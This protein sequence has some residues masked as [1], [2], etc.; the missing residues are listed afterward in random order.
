MN[1]LWGNR[2]VRIASRFRN[3]P[4]S[5]MKLAVSRVG[6]KFQRSV[7]DGAGAGAGAA[8]AESC[9]SLG[10]Y[11][12][13][14]SAQRLAVRA[15]NA[16]N[17]LK[18]AR[19]QIV[20][21]ETNFDRMANGAV[22]RS[23]EFERKLYITQSQLQRVAATAEAARIR[24]AAEVERVRGDL[25][26]LARQRD[27]A[28]GELQSA[29]KELEQERSEVVRAANER[30]ERDAVHKGALIE[31]E[32]MKVGLVALRDEL[33]ATAKERDRA[34]GELAELRVRDAN[35]SRRADESNLV[36]HEC[37]RRYGDLSDNVLALSNALSRELKLLKLSDNLNAD[38]SGDRTGSLYL[39]LIEGSLI[40]ALHEDPAGDP[41]S[42]GK[43]D[44]LRRN[45]GRDWPKTA[46][47]MIGKSRMRNIRHLL[48]TVIAEKIPGDV[49]EAGVWRGGACIYMKAILAAYGIADRRVWVADSFRG[50]PQPDAANYPADAGDVHH[51]YDELAISVDDV[52]RNFAR[53]G[54]LDDQVCFL[55]GWFKDTMPRAPIDK[56]ALLRLDGDM[57]ESTMQVLE[58]LYGKV[59]TG[60]FV[61]VDDYILGP[62]KQAV[63]DYRAKHGITEALQTVDG[64]A[65]YWQKNK[66]I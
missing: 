4:V 60:G 65:V 1:R 32:A 30:S 56:L 24:S 14:S 6:K 58:A 33:S 5:T 66:S 45:I 34:Y 64:A 61:I 42:G 15:E 17:Q 10:A 12:S 16:E 29:R 22:S 41:W 27:E 28:R 31:L 39:D 13:R 57:Y 11:V 26:L 23:A 9:A 50:L 18:A 48:S 54:L 51:T 55:E 47:S 43:F 21:M 40:G 62:C 20:E 7:V 52:K 46:L 37:V 53:Y 49:I 8:Q 3:E 2:Y 44:P 38:G 36:L 59:S 63:D 25:E 35:S 19:L